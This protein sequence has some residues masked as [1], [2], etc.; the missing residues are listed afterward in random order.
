M[1]STTKINVPYQTLPQLSPEAPL[2]PG[3]LLGTQWTEWS[4]CPQ[5]SSMAHTLPGCLQA[6]GSHVD[7]PC[8]SP[9]SVSNV[10]IVKG[11]MVEPLAFFQFG[12]FNFVGVYHNCCMCMS[13]CVDVSLYIF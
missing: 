5:S 6:A 2:N 12:G 1:F 8:S 11:S 7:S 4:Q 10:S 3:L 13:V 9:S